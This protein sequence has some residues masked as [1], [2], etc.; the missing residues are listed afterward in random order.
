MQEIR[1]KYLNSKCKLFDKVYGERLNPEQC[2]AVFTARGPLLVL[3][4]AGSGKT[5]VLV[6]RIAYLIKYGNA[7][8]SDY[9]PEGVSEEAV[10][11]LELAYEMNPDEISEILPQFIIEQTPPWSVLAITF[12]NKAAREIKNRL[13]ST[14]EDPDVANSV[15]SGTFHSVCLRILRKYF[16]RIALRE[17]FSIYDTDDK[18]RLVT[19]CMKELDIV[20]AYIM[21]EVPR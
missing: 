3:A 17:G 18:K 7:Y 13:L 14:F 6:N 11:A 20:E 9:V 12:T 10:R 15:W 16:D 2:R 8:F 1:E 19:I 4:G 21:V 5:T